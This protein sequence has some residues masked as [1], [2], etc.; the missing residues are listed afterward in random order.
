MMV[1]KITTVLLV[2]VLTQVTVVFAQSPKPNIVIIIADDL[3]YGDVEFNNGWIETPHLNRL[4]KDGLKFNDF[5]TSGAVCS[6]TRAGLL[7]GLYQ[8]RV[9][10]PGVIVAFKNNTEH[11]RGLDPSAITLPALLKNGG[12]TTALFGKWHLGYSKEFNPLHYG[13]DK[14]RGYLSGQ[15]DYHSHVD[16]AGN[17]DWWNGFDQS[18]EEGYSTHLITRYATDFIREKK[19][20]PFFLVVSHEAVHGP[21]QGPGDSAFRVAG[22]SS[23]EAPRGQALKDKKQAFKLMMQEMDKSI[24]E[25]MKTLKDVGCEEN[26]FIFFLSDNG[27]VNS[28]SSNLPFRGGKTQVWEGGHR[29]PAIAYWPGKIKPGASTDELCNS[30]DIMPTILSVSSIKTPKNYV[31]DGT[32]LAPLIFKGKD[33]GDRNFFWNAENQEFKYGVRNKNWKLVMSRNGD[34]YLFNMTEDKEEQN[35]LAE[36]NPS[37]VEKMNKLY[38]QWK[39]DVGL[40]KYYSN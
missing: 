16:L 25:I 28:V 11:K 35:N 15:I 31:S 1:I 2:A 13:F 8:Y 19:D 38:E 32:N 22:S 10:V 34:P 17:F 37:T 3:G 5:H 27:G 29:V 4:A 33:I 6:P 39:K 24:G 26:T 9:G 30:L 12:Y 21:Y 14:F 7:T 23:A 18:K 20:H 36:K 40:A